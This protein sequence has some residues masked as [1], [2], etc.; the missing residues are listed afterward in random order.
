MLALAAVTVFMS[1][2]GQSFSVA[3]FVDPML[4]ELGI[5]RTQYTFAYMTAT[6]IGGFS[7]PL[8]GRQ[9]DRF[10]AR[11]VLPLVA[12]GLALACGWMSALGSL[13][14]LYLG[15][16]LIR[17]LGQG[18]L[19]LISN[20]IIGEWFQSRRGLA[21]GI[22]AVGGTASVLIIPQ[23]NDA[24]IEAWG[25]R[26]AWLVLGGIVAVSLILP[27][28]VF[29]RDRPESLGLFPDWQFER[30]AHRATTAAL[31]STAEDYTVRQALRCGSFWKI[32]A[33]V[34]TVSLVGTGLMFHQ[35]SLLAEHGVDRSTALSALGVQ[36]IAATLSTLIAGILIDRL[37]A[38]FVL[39][40][41]MALEI[42]AIGLLIL[43]PSSGWIFV[44]SA[45]LGLHGGIIRSAGSIIWINYFGRTHQGAIQGVA[46]SVMVLAAALGPI[47]LALAHDFTGG[48]LSALLLFLLFPAA[49]GLAVLTAHPPNRNQTAVSGNS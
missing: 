46:M 47:P 20:W 26:Q 8:I 40:V 18:S 25:W 1:A 4:T 31:D 32:A 2:P 5:G 41:S 29:L 48:Y 6:L 39:A 11:F 14:G 38:R 21:A 10:G 35:V 12:A 23:I 42:C 3:A 13:T 7:L 33:V 19:T 30:P 28:A 27:A 49:A 45:L 44:Y 9:V 17:C 43:L 15:F 34:A 24:F 22:C 36:A 37:P 16:T